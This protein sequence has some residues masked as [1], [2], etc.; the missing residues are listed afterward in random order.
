MQLSCQFITSKREWSKR[1]IQ[2]CS[3]TAP[4]AMN[5]RLGW[6]WL[7]TSLGGKVE[8]RGVLCRWRLYFGEFC[9]NENSR[10]LES[11]DAHQKIPWKI[12][13]TVNFPV[14]M[15]ENTCIYFLGRSQK[16]LSKIGLWGVWSTQKQIFLK[17][18]CVPQNLGAFQKIRS[19][20]G[21]R[22]T[23]SE[24]VV[25]LSGQLSGNCRGCRATVGQLSGNCRATVGHCRATVG[26]CRATVGHC[27]ATVACGV[28]PSPCCT[29]RRFALKKLTFVNFVAIWLECRPNPR[30]TPFLPKNCAFPSF[31]TKN[32]RNQQNRFFWPY[33]SVIQSDHRKFPQTKTKQQIVRPPCASFRN[34]QKGDRNQFWRLPSQSEWSGV[35]WQQLDNC[36]LSV[37]KIWGELRSRR[38]PNSQQVLF[39]QNV[40]MY[41]KDTSTVLAFFLKSA[42]L[43]SDKR[44]SLVF[45]CIFLVGP[46]LGWHKS[47]TL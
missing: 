10:K 24:I 36:E 42:K 37:S 33:V 13:L 45:F 38:W 2:W 46:I 5:Q 15:S 14:Q 22:A 23:F 35:W 43:C 31:W 20:T 27:R 7:W 39:S 18:S 8:V 12:G 29:D 19:K 32:D 30:F 9:A 26:H 25:K 34:L 47:N 1:G 16:I 3:A 21:L 17:I 40:C 41:L 11:L 28:R 6:M 4:S 44:H